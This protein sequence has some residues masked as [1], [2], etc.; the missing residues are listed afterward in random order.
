MVVPNEIPQ[1][2]VGVYHHPLTIL[3]KIIEFNLL[4]QVSIGGAVNG[5]LLGFAMHPNSLGMEGGSIHTNIPG[6]PSGIVGITSGE[7]NG[8]AVQGSHFVAGFTVLLIA[9]HAA[10]VI[11]PD[12]LG[13]AIAVH[14]RHEGL[15]TLL[16]AGQFLFHDFDHDDLQFVHAV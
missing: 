13:D 7:H 3:G 6:G 10:I 16:L 11:A 2:D 9:F 8:I 15:E 1:S 14:E 4:S 12:P 5:S